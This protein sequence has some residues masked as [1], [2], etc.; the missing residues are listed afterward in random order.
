MTFEKNQYVKIVDTSGNFR[1]GYIANIQEK[2]SVFVIDLFE[3]AESKIEFDRLS[4]GED[5]N[6]ASL[7]S[8]IE[9]SIVP[10][11][12]VG[13]TTNEIAE[14]LCNAPATIRAHLRTLRI[15]LSLENRTQLIA[16]SQ[17]LNSILEDHNG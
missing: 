4:G 6:Y 2:G 11:L 3:E 14:E 17:G 16:F 13:K 9:K 12:A 8:D 1:Y 10:M 15:K 5:I 7:L